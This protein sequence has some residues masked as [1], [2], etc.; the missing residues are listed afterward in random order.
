[1]DAIQAH[2]KLDK[3]DNHDNQREER[4]NDLD[5]DLV[6]EIDST[7][8]NCGAKF[9]LKREMEK[10]LILAIGEESDWAEGPRCARWCN[11]SRCRSRERRS[12]RRR[13]HLSAARH[14]AL[15]T[16]QWAEK[17]ASSK[18]LRT[19]K[20]LSRSQ[21]R[22]VLI[23]TSVLQCSHYSLFFCVAFTSFLSSHQIP[24]IVDQSSF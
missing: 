15:P 2:R 23:R 1:M 19:T 20:K 18:Q 5:E 12:F 3:G 17:G 21:R 10:E 14:S 7:L 4:L 9:S 13:L 8:R 11:D 24:Q 22:G 6:E 16:K